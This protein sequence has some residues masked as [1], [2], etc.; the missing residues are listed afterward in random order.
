VS[1][2]KSGGALGL[3]VEVELELESGLESGLVG[4]GVVGGVENLSSLSFTSG[5]AVMSSGAFMLGVGSGSVATLVV[6]AGTVAGAAE[7]AVVFWSRLTK[8]CG[9]GSDV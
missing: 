1:I 6:V 2:L 4:G 3:E 8:S 5:V 9:C 7:A